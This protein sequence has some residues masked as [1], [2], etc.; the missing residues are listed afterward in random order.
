MRARTQH[1]LQV[2]VGVLSNDGCP[3]PLGLLRRIGDGLRAVE[4][5]IGN[6]KSTIRKVLF[7]GVVAHQI[8]D[9]ACQ[10]VG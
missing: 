8:R 1:R 3:L 2:G 6:R 10:S 9:R 5:E 7:G 4:V